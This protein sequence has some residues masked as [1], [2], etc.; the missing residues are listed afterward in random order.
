MKISGK[1]YT[2]VAIMGAVTVMVAAMAVYALR[3]YDKQTSLLNQTAQRA[4]YAEH[5]NRLISA[6][7]MESRGVYMSETSDSA[8]QFAEGIRKY[9]DEMD[10]TIS[11][12]R[13]IVPPDRL[14][15][16]DELAKRA[17]EF[18]AFRLETARLGVDV[19][20]AAASEQGNNESNRRNRKEFQ[21]LLDSQV[22]AIFGQLA[23]IRANMQNFQDRMMNLVVGAAV[24]GLAFAVGLGA[25]I[26][27][28]LLSR[29]LRRVSGVL[30]QMAAGNYDIE[31]ETRRSR[32]E[33][34]AIWDATEHFR[35]ALIEGERLKSEQAAIDARAE[36]SKRAM[37]NEL[38]E[39][40]EA[41]VI[42]VV[43]SVSAAAAQLEKHAAAMTAAAEATNYK[44]LAVSSA[45][46]QATNNVHTVASAAEPSAEAIRQRISS[47]ARSIW[48]LRLAAA[49][50]RPS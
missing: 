11:Q 41:Q 16:F 47:V 43:R 28:F 32:D 39:A 26:G 40:F 24:I 35:D 10:K 8:M 13:A 49:L 19:S 37:L 3:Q 21:D 20:P 25:W 6:V 5:L 27:T 9:L 36:E 42:G 4:F 50:I 2:I 33:V 48:P 46:D 7:V 12:W 31:L 29:P 14:A 23:S 30:Q 45:S 1:I 44:S 34:G 38:A 17:A 18:R 15:S 22:E